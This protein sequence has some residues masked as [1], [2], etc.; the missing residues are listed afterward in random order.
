MHSLLKKIL[1]VAGAIVVAVVLFFA[2]LWLPTFN[3]AQPTEFGASFSKSYAESMG[4]DWQETYLAILDDLEVRRLRLSSE[5]DEIETSDGLYDFSALDWQIA[6][7]EKRGAKILLAVGERQPRWPECHAPAW[8]FLS[9]RGEVE[10]R[11][12]NFV[13]TVV[14][15]Y[16]DSP[17]L[18]MWQVENEPFLNVF[19]ECPRG[20]VNFLRQEIDLVKSLD[21]RPILITDSGELS[22]WRRTA[23]LGDYF[24]TSIYRLVYNPLV[25]YF[26]H[27]FPPAFYRLK[28][29]LVGLSRE[30][31]IISELQVEPWVSEGS[32]ADMPL[33]QQKNL[34]GPER[35]ENHIDFARKTGFSPAY[36]W[37]VE[38]WY[39]LKLKGD[40]SAWQ[41]GRNLW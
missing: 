39:W 23:H 22:T 1:I 34:M 9:P 21:D 13:K 38:W 14:E 30:K 18:E 4:L 24:G 3:R 36:L 29:A 40:D 16:K 26:H 32:I 19:G 10:E 25:G 37:G 20:N 12:L 11:L 28:A 6:E 2:V 35:I 31:V 33:D 8:L 41:V 5:W 15:R 27:F 17:V 7:A